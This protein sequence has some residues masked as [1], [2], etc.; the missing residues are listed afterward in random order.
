MPVPK[1]QPG[2]RIAPLEVESIQGE[3]VALPDS[4]LMT[5]LQFRRYAGCPICNLHLRTFDRRHDE[6]LSAGIREVVVFHS[7]QESLRE[8]H[9]EAP[10]PMIADPKRHLYIQFGVEQSP[11]A[12]LD[13]RAWVG[14]A[15]AIWNVGIAVPGRGESPLGLPGEFLIRPDGTVLDRKYGV[16]ASDQWD[17]DWVLTRVAAC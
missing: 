2:D 3:L 6:L 13:P 10:F 7:S 4:R 5:H 14:A 9:A 16:H 8:H 12:I 11:R 15:R 1:L 17:L